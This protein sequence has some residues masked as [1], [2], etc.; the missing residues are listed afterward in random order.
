MVLTTLSNLAPSLL[1]VSSAKTLVTALVGELRLVP[2]RLTAYAAGLSLVSTA[3]P[4]NMPCWDLLENALRLFDSYLLG[5]WPNN[6]E[7]DSQ[8]S[9]DEVLDEVLGAPHKQD[10]LMNGLVALCIAADL[11]TRSPNEEAEAA[12]TRKFSHHDPTLTS[13]ICISPKLSCFCLP[14]TCQS[15]PFQYRLV[16]PN[17]C[18]PPHLTHGY[19]LYRQR[20]LFY[21]KEG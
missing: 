14:R 8:S 17:P 6:Q 16:A 11:C 12:E 18:Q 21:Y 13:L 15:I 1:P 10:E 4:N 2:P 7:D 9:Q 19:A 3:S 20:L 5:Q